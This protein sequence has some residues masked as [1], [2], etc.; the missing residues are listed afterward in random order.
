M[1]GPFM[2]Y[3]LDGAKFPTLEELITALYPLYADKMSEAEFRKYVQENV[4]EE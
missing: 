4:K 1:R 2:A 3:K